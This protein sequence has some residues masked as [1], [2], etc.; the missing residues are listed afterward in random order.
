MELG[1][2]QAAEER[3]GEGGA[4]LDCPWVGKF[5]PNPTSI[6]AAEGWTKWLE[7]SAAHLVVLKLLGVRI[8][9]DYL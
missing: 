1:S 9:F 2:P 6:A 3:H 4:S 8:A 5:E 7:S